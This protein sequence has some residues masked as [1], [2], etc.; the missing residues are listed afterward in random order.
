M[1]SKN[2]MLQR[3]QTIYLLIAALV[4]GGLVFLLSLWK[5]ANSVDFF[6]MDAIKTSNVLL[7]AMSILFFVSA[8]I[9]ICTLFLFKNRSLQLAMGR[10]NILINFI[11]LGIV[12]YF[13]QHISVETEVS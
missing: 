10:L 7:I 3:V 6:V 4:S 2:K 13:S 1:N 11:L 8:F 9:S 5:G 12:V